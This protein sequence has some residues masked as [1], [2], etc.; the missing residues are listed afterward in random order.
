[1]ASPTVPARFSVRWRLLAAFLGIG[2]F[3]MLAA[4]AGVYV[5]GQVAGVLE[6]I[7]ERR[8]PAALAAL[9]LSRQ[10][11]RI[12]AAA[13]ELLTVRSQTGH[14]DVSAEIAH[15]VGRLEMLLAQ[16]KESAT[17][18][19]AVAE[20]EATRA[21][22]TISTRSTAWSRAGSGSPKARTSCSHA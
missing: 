21:C 18:T 14:Q 11:E 10:V 5:F 6:R 1:L 9:E 3:A 20:L 22:A 2:I 16:V 17:D 8:A 19:A 15:E 7:T 12:V 13:P 4:A